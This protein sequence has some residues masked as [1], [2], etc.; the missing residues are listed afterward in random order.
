MEFEIDE[1]SGKRA[2]IHGAPTIVPVFAWREVSRIMK[3]GFIK[4]G[5][6]HGKDN[7]YNIPVQPASNLSYSL[8]SKVGKTGMG[9]V[10]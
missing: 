2:K 7:W 6:E 8:G 3:D 5:I 4:Y 10:H 1:A 9:Q